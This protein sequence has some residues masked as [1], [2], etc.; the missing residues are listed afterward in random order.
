MGVVSE[1][2]L[3][4]ALGK[5]LGCKTLGNFSM[6]AFEPEVLVL[7]STEFV[8][9]HQVFP[10]QYKDFML[11][12]AISDP[13]DRET[14]RKISS[15]TGLQVMPVIAPKSEIIN[16]ISRHYLNTRITPD[17]S[18]GI[19]VVDGSAIIATVVKMALVK[20]G[21]HVI[22]ATDG[23]DAVKL[24]TTQRPRLVIT[25]TQLPG[26]DGFSLLQFIKAHPLIA[27]I[28]VIMLTTQ[29]SAE[30]EQ[31]AFNAGFFDFIAKPVQP[32][33]VTMRVKRALAITDRLQ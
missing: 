33:R 8:I 6:R 28:P 22:T 10:L 25:E 31:T 16:A 29:A 24:T 12:V 23:I 32:L 13:H 15:I 14:T 9:K 21:F 18:D 2:E 4:E 27:N 30:D 5:Q 17:T 11:A 1:F 3:I 20:E 19:L 7:L 26:L